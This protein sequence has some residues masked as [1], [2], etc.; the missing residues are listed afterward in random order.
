MDDFLNFKKMISSTLI[1]LIYVLGALALVIW[2]I[3]VL[4]AAIKKGVDYESWTIVIIGISQFLGIA[5]G[6][7]LVFR[8]LCEGVIVLFSI[9]ENL[10]EINK[11]TG[12][13]N[14]QPSYMGTSSNSTASSANS[15]NGKQKVLCPKCGA[16]YQKAFFNGK[17]T[18]GRFFCDK[19]NYEIT[20]S[21]LVFGD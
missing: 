8:L 6:G 21:N 17:L 2:G 3:V 10:V 19:C 18:A 9:Q 11:K 16:D 1:K 13:G 15:V 5:V 20:D 4:V 12:Y 7:N 14:A